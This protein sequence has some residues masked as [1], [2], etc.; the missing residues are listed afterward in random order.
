VVIAARLS[1]RRHIIR[2]SFDTEQNRNSML[3]PKQ[4]STP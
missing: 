3:Q 2:I 4:P 1:H